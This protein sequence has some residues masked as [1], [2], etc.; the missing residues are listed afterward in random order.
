MVVSGRG[1]ILPSFEGNII[2]HEI[3]IPIKQSEFE[4]K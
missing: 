4:G 2:H 3:K 1:F